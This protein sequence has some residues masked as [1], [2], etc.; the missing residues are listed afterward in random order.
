MVRVCFASRG[1]SS[2]RLAPFPPW[3]VYRLDPL[4]DFATLGV[5]VDVDL[6]MRAIV[7]ALLRLDPPRRASR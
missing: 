3:A 1:V 7:R 6:R 2:S 4:G 5:A